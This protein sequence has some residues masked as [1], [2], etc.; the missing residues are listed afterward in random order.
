MQLTKTC[1]GCKEKFR[2]EEL[3]EYASAAATIPHWY[4]SKCLKEKQD[5][6]HF[7]DKVCQIFG[8]KSPGPRIWTERKRLK[9]TYGYTDDTIIDC[10]DYIYNVRH[11]KK[12]SESLSLIT[13]KMV[14]A[15]KAYKGGQ[16][17]QAGA[18]I[19]AMKQPIEKVEVI[20]EENTTSNKANRN[21]DDYLLD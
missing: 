10:L 13:P 11:Y 2:K 17:A 5:R 4:C 16:A 1:Y 7:S 12:L 8:I 19:A 14:Y 20:I 9:E 21:F 15:M 6:E 3:I 18:L